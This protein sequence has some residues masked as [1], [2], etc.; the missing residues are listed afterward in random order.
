MSADHL[1][2]RLADG[3]TAGE[4]HDEEVAADQRLEWGLMVKEIISIC[5]VVAVLV[6]RHLWF[7]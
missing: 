6:V 1:L 7:V 2:I 4:V 3:R 5:I